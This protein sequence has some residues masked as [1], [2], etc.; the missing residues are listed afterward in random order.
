[1]GVA[2]TEPIERRA[3]CRAET[4]RPRPREA[5]QTVQATDGEA[6]GA[7]TDQELVARRDAEAGR[8]HGPIVVVGEHYSVVVNVFF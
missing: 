8:A 2:A 7:I 3:G 6:V 1:M 5:V 4:P